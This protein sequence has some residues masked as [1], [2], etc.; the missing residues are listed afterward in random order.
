M[1]ILVGA[2]GIEH[3]PKSNKPNRCTAL[4]L[5]EQGQL[6]ILLTK[7]CENWHSGH[8]ARQEQFLFAIQ[9]LAE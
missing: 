5:T 4:Q 3:S 6:L 1:W 7:T 2:V 9:H 8:S